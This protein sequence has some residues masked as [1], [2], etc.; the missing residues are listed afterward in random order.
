MSNL[1]VYIDWTEVL[2]R[3]TDIAV[4]ITRALL[5]LWHGYMHKEVNI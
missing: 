1:N 3:M 4:A 2:E 5:I